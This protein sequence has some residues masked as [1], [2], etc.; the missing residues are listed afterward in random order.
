MTGEF[1]VSAKTVVAV[2]LPGMEIQ[3]IRELLNA[4]GDDNE[5]STALGSR[6]Y[7]KAA[8]ESENVKLYV[9]KS[10]IKSVRKISLACY[11]HRSA[12]LNV[13]EWP[14][15]AQRVN[16]MPDRWPASAGSLMTIRQKQTTLPSTTFLNQKSKKSTKICKFF[17]SH[18]PSTLNL[19]PE[20]I[21]KRL[22]SLARVNTGITSLDRLWDG[23]S[24]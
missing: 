17:L 14:L 3:G 6:T 10:Q 4:A 9:R 13:E 12:L 5:V 23:F 19:T 20:Q 15:L 11:F 2:P 22:D 24:R 16:T 1:A 21:N 8:Q 18:T 7:H